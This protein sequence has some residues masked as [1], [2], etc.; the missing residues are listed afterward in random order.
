MFLHIFSVL[1]LF[2]DY[3]DLILCLH[4]IC[5]NMCVQTL[6]NHIAHLEDNKNA[7]GKEYCIIVME[8]ILSLGLP[9]CPRLRFE[10]HFYMVVCA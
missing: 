8:I 7:K 9:S 3:R 5:S 6:Q 4:S 1:D 10:N 2:E